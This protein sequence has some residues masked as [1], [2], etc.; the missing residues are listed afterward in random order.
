MRD[1]SAWTPLWGFLRL[2][3]VSAVLVASAVNGQILYGAAGWAIGF[4]VPAVWLM[5]RE[6][7]RTMEH[8]NGNRNQA[9]QHD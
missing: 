6:Q 3:L 2:G 1:V 8:A 5:F 9:N 4:A 7:D